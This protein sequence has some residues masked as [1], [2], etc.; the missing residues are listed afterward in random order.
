MHVIDVGRYDSEIRDPGALHADQRAQIAVKLC[1][2]TLTSDGVLPALWGRGIGGDR[3]RVICQAVSEFFTG[4]FLQVSTQVS[5][6]A[7]LPRPSKHSPPRTLS[8]FFTP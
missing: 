1:G 5:S 7:D 6:T 2:A 4:N 3:Y 8:E